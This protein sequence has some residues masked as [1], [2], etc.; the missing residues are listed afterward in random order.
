M[1]KRGKRFDVGNERNE[2]DNGI[3]LDLD[4]EK[5][6]RNDPWVSRIERRAKF[7]HY[8]LTERGRASH[9]D[10]F[11]AG[12]AIRNQSSPRD[13]R[14]TSRADSGSKTSGKNVARLSTGRLSSSPPGNSPRSPIFRLRGIFHPLDHAKTIDRAEVISDKAILI[15]IIVCSV[16]RKGGG[17]KKEKEKKKLMTRNDSP[18]SPSLSLLP[19]FFLSPFFLFFHHHGSCYER[20]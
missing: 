14:C 18:R 3:D 12:R 5:S 16:V 7:F 6:R 2:D 20:R 13:G 9:L 19:P 8:S 4:V 15:L 10:W 11:L 17:E 1:E